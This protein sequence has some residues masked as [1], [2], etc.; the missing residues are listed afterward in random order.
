MRTKLKLAYIVGTYPCLTTTFID[1]EIVGLRRRGAEVEVVAVRRPDGLLSQEQLRLRGETRY[2][3]PARWGTFVMANVSF[4]VRRPWAYLQTLLYLVTR[5]RLSFQARLLTS[6]HFAM[7][8]YVAHLL[9]KRQVHQ[10]HAHFIDRAATLALVASRLLDI[11]Y[12]VTAHA[13]DI[14]VGPILLA[15]KLRGAEFIATC[16]GFNEQY[17]ARL[18]TNSFAHKLRRIY[19]GLDLSTY[20]PA[21]KKMPQRPRLIAVGQLKEKKGFVYLIKACQ[22]LKSQGYQFD[23][24]I[25]GAGPQRQ[26]LEELIRELGLQDTVTLY[27]ALPHSEVIEKY[28]RATIFVL[29]CIVG[30][31]GARDGIPNVVLEALAMQIPVVST[32]HSGI[33]EVVRNGINGL[34]VPPQDAT[35]LATA[36]AG[37]LD[38]PQLRQDLG[39]QGRQTVVEKFD[40]D[41]NVSE[42]MSEFAA[43]A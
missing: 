31:D 11:P 17:L 16:T 15:E 32:E 1:R 8:V 42:L 25:V 21:M 43:H 20:D 7:G 22:L 34:L 26:E 5:P 6:C 27:G 39:E 23:C 28:K 19:H 35:A 3:L 40:I 12:S 29:P 13:N 18:G 2:L 37:L 10:I 41:N 36:V 9:R 33:P 30:A 14:F 24:D 38:D 4:L